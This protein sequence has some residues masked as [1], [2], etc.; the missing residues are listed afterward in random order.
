M[1][2]PLPPRRTDAMRS[3]D[4]KPLFTVSNH[5]GPQTGECRLFDG[6]SP[7][8]SHSYFENAYGEQSVFVH[9]RVS[10]ECVVWCGDAGWEPHVG[11]HGHVDGG[12]LGPEE[13]AWIHGCLLAI[14]RRSGEDTGPAGSC[15]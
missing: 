14:R 7:T 5:H 1:I 12:N 4:P 9:D 8:H 6:D 13:L 10:G 11:R 3:P 15:A 2:A